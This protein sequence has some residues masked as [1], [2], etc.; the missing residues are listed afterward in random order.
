MV[1]R[2]QNAR[3]VFKPSVRLY[4]QRRALIHSRCDAALLLVGC[5]VAAARV[6]D[7]LAP[8]LW[9]KGNL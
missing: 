7:H 1:L 2:Q 8:V 5:Q 4:R 9:Q 6:G 3:L